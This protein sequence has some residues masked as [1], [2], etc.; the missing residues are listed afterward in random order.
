MNMM[1]IT[2]I[3]YRTRKNLEID[4]VFFINFIAAR[5]VGTNIQEAAKQAVEQG[6]FPHRRI[7]CTARRRDR[8]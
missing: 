1:N 2:L 4:L 7:R 6:K 8:D 5:L 3:S